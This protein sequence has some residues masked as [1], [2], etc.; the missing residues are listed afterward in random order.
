MDSLE[1]RLSDIHYNISQEVDKNLKKIRDLCSSDEEF[2]RRVR[3]EKHSNIEI[4][5]FDD[6]PNFY[7]KFKIEGN[8]ATWKVMRF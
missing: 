3:S 2:S 1:Y 8:I 4:F 5:Y 6:I 7:S